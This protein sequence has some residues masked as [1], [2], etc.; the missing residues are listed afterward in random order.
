MDRAVKNGKLFTLDVRAGKDGTPDW[1][2]TNYKG[3]AGA[4]PVAPLKFK[5]WGSEEKPP[6]NSCGFDMRLGSPTDAAYREIYI[7][8]INELATHVAS[9]LRWFQALAH[10][11]VSGANFISSE[12]RLPKRCYDGDE[13]GRLD[14]VAGDRC[15]CNSQTWAEAGYLPDGLYEFYRLVENTIYTAFQKRKSLGYQLIQAGFPKVQSATN[16]EG[17]SLQDQHGQDLLSPPGIADDDLKGTVQTE[18]V[19]E[20]GRKGRFVDLSGADDL[21]AGKLFVPQHSGLHRLPDD[22]GLAPCLQAMAVNK[23]TQQAAFPITKGQKISNDGACPNWWAVKEGTSFEQ[24]MGFQTVNPNGG[25][26]S[27]ADLESALWN[28]T[29]NSNGVFLEVY[30]QILWDVY[31]SRGSGATAA[32]PGRLS[33]KAASKP[34]PLL[35][36]FECLVTRTPRQTEGIERPGKPAPA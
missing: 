10:V 29:I 32:V 27:P 3:P 28:L 18:T 17:D 35:Q 6:P 34:G 20:E 8:M 25:V 4:G 12:A 22:D 31:H 9:D 21:A 24:V 5:D 15:L 7:A 36:E 30:E 13:D 11:K 23:Q 19:L 2:F 1:I 26:D 33:V 14:V 16:F